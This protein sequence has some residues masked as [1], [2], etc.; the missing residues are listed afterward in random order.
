MELLPIKEKLEENETFLDNPWCREYLQMS[1][2]YYQKIG[3]VPPWIGYYAQLNGEFVGSAGFKGQPVDGKVEIAYG[4][5][6]DFQQ[7]GLGTKICKALVDLVQKTNPQ[8][9]ISARTLPENNASARILEKNNFVCM[10][11][12]DDPEDGEV[13]EWVFQKMT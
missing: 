2:D 9:T 8:I 7:Q 6:D 3:Y 12:V 5:F 4:I 13:W 11:I 10:G 1:I